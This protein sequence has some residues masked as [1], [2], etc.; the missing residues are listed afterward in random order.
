MVGEA[1][2]KD[3]FYKDAIEMM[4][5]LASLQTESFGGAEAEV[6]QY[7]LKAWIRIA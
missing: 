6:K 7:L 5:F 2:G 1:A 3:K 4:S